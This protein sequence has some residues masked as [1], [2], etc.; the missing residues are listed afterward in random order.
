M[1]S[2]K[3]SILSKPDITATSMEQLATQLFPNCS[4]DTFTF[5]KPNILQINQNKS[6][7][8]EINRFDYDTFKLL[9]QFVD[10][11]Y[12]LPIKKEYHG[13]RYPGFYLEGNSLSNFNYFQPTEG[14]S[15][16]TKFMQ[17]DGLYN[18]KLSGACVT[19]KDFYEVNFDNSTGLIDSKSLPVFRNVQNKVKNSII[20]HGVEIHFSSPINTFIKNTLKDNDMERLGNFFKDIPEDLCIG[21]EFYSFLKSNK[22]TSYIKK[23]YPHLEE[24]SEFKGNYSIYAHFN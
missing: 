7:Q 16:V 4:P 10:T 23:N 13:F 20:S 6:M 24:V 18:C 9:L 2:I 11:I 1:R 19:F 8:Q 3:E 5:P 12:L 17:V 21:N 14:T 22:P 15:K